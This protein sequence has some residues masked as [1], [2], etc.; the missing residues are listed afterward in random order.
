MKDFLKE[1]GIIIGSF[2]SATLFFM[3]INSF[4]LSA[5]I[6]LP[7]SPEKAG[8]EFLG[9]Q[10]LATEAGHD[11][12]VSQIGEVTS[13]VFL[14]IKSTM[15]IIAVAWLVWTGVMMVSSANKEDMIT[16]GRRMATYTI[17]GL[18]ILLLIEPMVM[19]VFYGGRDIS[20]E[21]TGINDLQNAYTNFSVETRALVSWI[22]AILVFVAMA[23]L[24]LAGMTIVFA[25]G[26][27]DT[28]SSGKKM[29]LPIFFGLLVIAFNEVIVDQIIYRSVYNGSRV[30]FDVGENNANIFIKELLGLV[31]YFLFFVA[32]IAFALLVYGGFLYV[33]SFG[34]DERSGVGKKIFINATIG[35]IIILISFTLTYSLVGL[36]F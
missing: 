2:L 32:T 10:N 15:G 26:E 18:M 23:Y 35:L 27:E 22:E 30:L 25:F 4:H 29:I 5:S 19:D 24:I 9:G 28:L 16:K 8:I 14:L 1:Y 11:S 36:K 34:D 6:T 21:N 31:Q 20:I 13:A 7:F 33:I 17:L 3:S 12:G